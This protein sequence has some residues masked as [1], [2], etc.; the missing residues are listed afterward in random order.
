MKL[1]SSEFPEMTLKNLKS[2]KDADE[3]EFLKLIMKCSNLFKKMI[4]Y[5]HFKTN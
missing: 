1:K 3:I 4:N 5:N 2:L